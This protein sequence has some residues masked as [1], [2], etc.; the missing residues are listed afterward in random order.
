MVDA[1]P[2]SVPVAVADIPD[3]GLSVAIAADEPTRAAIAKMAE[4]RALPRLEAAFDLARLGGDRI[5]VTGNVIAQVGQTCVV[6]LEPIESDVAEAVDIVFAPAA[7]IAVPTGAEDMPLESEEEPPEP[8]QD[9]RIDLGA[10]AVEFL[11][12]GIDPY[13]RKP[14]AA[15]ELQPAPEGAEDHPFAALAA[16]KGGGGAKDGGGG[17][18]G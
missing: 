6:T 3:T 12:L 17:A 2:W 7:E 18:Q 13:P 4:L 11:M 15:F 8:L 1:M 9:G 14:G 10:L 5:K 16:L